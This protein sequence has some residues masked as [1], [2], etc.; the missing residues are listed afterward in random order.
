MPNEISDADNKASRVNAERRKA[1]FY[2]MTLP[3]IALI[4]SGIIGAGGSITY[5]NNA[6]ADVKELKKQHKEDIDRV[7]EMQEKQI[8]EIREQMKEQRQD[9]KEIQRDIK[10]I[11][12]AL[13]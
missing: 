10:Q 6:A 5:W 2:G 13:K 3:E 1:F 9:S 8:A 12:R 4:L 7:V 11:L